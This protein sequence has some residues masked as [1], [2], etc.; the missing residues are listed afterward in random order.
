MKVGLNCYLTAGILTKL[1]NKCLLSSSPPNLPQ[2]LKIIAQ[3]C[4]VFYSNMQLIF[5]SEQKLSKTLVTQTMQSHCHKKIDNRKEVAKVRNQII[6]ALFWA[7][8]K[9]WPLLIWSLRGF[10]GLWE[11]LMQRSVSSGEGWDSLQPSDAL[12]ATQMS[13][14]AVIDRHF[15]GDC[16]P[17]GCKVVSQACAD[18]SLMGLQKSLTCLRIQHR[19]SRIH[20]DQF[21]YLFS[22]YHFGL[23]RLQGSNIGSPFEMFF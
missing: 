4:W 7:C 23:L 16:L 2:V 13:D 9:D 3:N 1:L 21:D 18:H 14:E 11:V 20:R 5:S 10:I 12:S 6:R 17:F 8:T 22:Y 19:F 15:I